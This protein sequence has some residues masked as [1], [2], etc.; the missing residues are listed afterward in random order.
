MRKYLQTIAIM[1]ADMLAIVIAGMLSILII[2]FYSHDINFTHEIFHIGASKL[3]II[4]A[5]MLFWHA[6]HYS[7]RQPF[8]QEIIFPQFYKKRF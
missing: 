5:I 2:S 8:W 3:L 6:G 4:L 7:R 1:L